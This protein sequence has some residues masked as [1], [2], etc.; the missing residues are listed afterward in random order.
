[1]DNRMQMQMAEQEFELVT[2]LLRKI[3]NRCYEKCHDKTYASGDATTRESLCMDKC[4][5]KY[6]EVNKNVNDRL[7]AASQAKME[8]QKR[9]QEFQEKRRKRKYGS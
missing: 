9:V 7:Q 6:F 4:V 5:M 1:M 2:E 8:Q 3:T